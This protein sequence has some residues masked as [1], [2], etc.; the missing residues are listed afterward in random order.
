VLVLHPNLPALYRRW[1]EALEE[2]LT[3]PESAGPATE[4]LPALVNAIRVFPG[5]RLGEVSVT[6]RGDLAAFLRADAA[7]P[8][9]R[10][11]LSGRAQP[12]WTTAVALCSM[13][14]R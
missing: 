8:Q 5:E 11:R 2:A 3:D 12:F 7:L 14:E 6:L 4:A 9:F 10:G 1:V 13:G